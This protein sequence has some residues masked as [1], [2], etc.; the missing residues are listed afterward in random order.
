MFLKRRFYISKVIVA[1]NGTTWIYIQTTTV[2]FFFPAI[3]SG[4]H[5]SQGSV[6]LPWEV[7]LPKCEDLTTD[8]P[9]TSSTATHAVVSTS[10]TASATYAVMSTSP[11]AT[12]TRAVISTS[13]TATATH[14]VISTSPTATATHSVISTFPTANAT[15]VVISTSPTTPTSQSTGSSS[16]TTTTRVESPMSSFGTPQAKNSTGSEISAASKRC[17]WK[18]LN[19][20]NS[21][22]MICAWAMYMYIGVT[23]IVTLS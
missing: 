11:T 15:Q 7:G 18:R 2:C 13:P 21:S 8:L 19:R 14:A 12:A 6:Q 9:L 10:P 22:S 1:L 17:K 4:R 23:F 20:R 16:V 3:D 5:Y